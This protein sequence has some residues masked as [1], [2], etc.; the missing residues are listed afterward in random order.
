MSPHGFI[1]PVSDF[2]SAS[3]QPTALLI[4]K[5]IGKL[6]NA[7][8]NFG[9]TE[10]WWGGTE[11]LRYIACLPFTSVLCVTSL[12]M[13]MLM[14]KQSWT[15][16]IAP[17]AITLASAPIDTIWRAIDL[18]FRVQVHAVIAH[19]SGHSFDSLWAT[20]Q[21][22]L[23]P[24]LKLFYSV[25]THHQWVYLSSLHS[26]IMEN[27]HFTIMLI[28]CL[29]AEQSSIKAETSRVS[30]CEIPYMLSFSIS[31]IYCYGSLIR[32]L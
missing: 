12:E 11:L 14:N 5:C 4:G 26:G 13:C 1:C 31:N 21:A 3:W 29:I 7:I 25:F 28:K 22:H 20:C 27:P 6:Q 32:F 16:S 17:W 9:S 23:W 8:L 30:A 15:W 18:A 19:T 10:V 24:G 2:F